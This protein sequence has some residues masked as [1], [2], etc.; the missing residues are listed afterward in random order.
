MRKVKE[1]MDETM[2]GIFCSEDSEA[3]LL[4]YRVPAMIAAPKIYGL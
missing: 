1:G 3:L 2:Q 4:L